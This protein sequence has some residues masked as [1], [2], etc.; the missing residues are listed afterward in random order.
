MMVKLL[1]ISW[2]YRCAVMVKARACLDITYT[3]IKGIKL[4][5]TENNLVIS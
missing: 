2:T 1:F 4:L 5:S 3:V